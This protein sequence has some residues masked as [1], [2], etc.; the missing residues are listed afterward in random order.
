MDVGCETWLDCAEC[1]RPS[2][3]NQGLA[4]ISNR[5]IYGYD[6]GARMYGGTHPESCLYL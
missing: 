1:G 4:N 6:M 5:F 3:S 2:R